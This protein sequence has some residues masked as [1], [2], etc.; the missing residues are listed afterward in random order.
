[1]N[2]FAEVSEMQAFDETIVKELERVQVK[3]VETWEMTLQKLYES[4]E[5]LV[6]EQEVFE[7]A[8]QNI[9]I[10]IY[11]NHLLKVIGGMAETKL[12]E[13]HEQIES[14]VKAFQKEANKAN[15]SKGKLSNVGLQL[16]QLLAI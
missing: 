15:E 14:E 11:L 7:M 2:T 8:I 12:D 16:R 4:R 6:K 3:L 9:R 10:K 5:A 1:M 13:L